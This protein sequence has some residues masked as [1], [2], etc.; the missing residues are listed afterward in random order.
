[1]R[2]TVD[3]ASCAAT[4][5]CEMICPEVFEVDLVAEVKTEHPDPFLHDQ[6]RDAADAC[7]TGAIH[8]LED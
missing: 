5:Q 6:V 2:V 4:G 3:D 8:L 1:M 7:P